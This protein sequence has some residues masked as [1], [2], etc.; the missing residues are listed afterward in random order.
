MYATKFRSE[1]FI[2]FEHV[3]RYLRRA[4]RA[5]IRFAR[6][7]AEHNRLQRTLCAPVDHLRKL[8][9][10]G[11]S[12][13]IG[14]ETKI[15][16]KSLL[17][18]EA[19]R[20]QVHRLRKLLIGGRNSFARA[21]KRVASK[22]LQLQDALRIRE[23]G[24]KMLL[25]SSLDA[26]V[27]INNE[28]RFLDANPKAL[29]LFRVSEKNMKKFTIDVFLSRSEISKFDG[30]VSPFV[31][32]AEKYGK[33]E[34]RRLDGSLLIAE[35]I[36]VANFAPFRHLCRFRNVS[37]IDQYRPTTL[38]RPTSQSVVQHNSARSEIS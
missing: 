35:Y 31:K 10:K 24:L 37:A 19:L 30:N 28:R 34:I 8:L 21:G 17:L 7:I 25:A 12:T 13:F 20:A 36:Y 2:A 38:R 1:L 6:S 22:P 29:D 11:Q 26:I 18:Q 3:T 14:L 23:N 9:H 5:L 32:R 4:R 16:V 33:C 15:A 27:V